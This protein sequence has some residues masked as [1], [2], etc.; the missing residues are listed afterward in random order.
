MNPVRNSLFQFLWQDDV[1]GNVD[2]PPATRLRAAHR[3]A[4]PAACVER[5]G[6][7]RRRAFRETGLAGRR[8][9]NGSICRLEW[10]L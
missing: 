4:H 6:R 8:I 2:T 5:T 7:L 10:R 9:E 3:S 1:G